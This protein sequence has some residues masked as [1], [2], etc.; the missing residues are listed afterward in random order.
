MRNY[1]SLV[2]K[3]MIQA[4]VALALALT[5]NACRS[6]KGQTITLGMA[7][8]DSEAKDSTKKNSKKQPSEVTA[9]VLEETAEVTESRLVDN[10]VLE[11]KKNQVASLQGEIDTREKKKVELLQQAK[12]LEASIAAEEKD[13]NS[14]AVQYTRYQ[15]GAIGYA[16]NVKSKKNIEEYK[17]AHA[18]LNE[19]ITKL[20]IESAEYSKQIESLATEITALQAKG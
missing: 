15:L 7:A 17:A 9:S 14:P 6:E 2:P 3:I 11:D 19:D 18:K 4:T 1:S 8:Q 5:L 13:L 20:D 10:S 12:D 16:A